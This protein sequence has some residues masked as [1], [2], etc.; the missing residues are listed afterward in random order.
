MQEAFSAERARELEAMQRSNRGILL[1]A[2]TFAAIGFL[3]LLIMTFFQWRT[4]RSLAEISAGL[5][6]ALGFGPGS[7]DPAL[8]PGDSRQRQG[9]PVEQ[10]NLRLL[11]AIDS[12]KSASRAWSR[13]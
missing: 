13:R 7:A 3:A 8:G 12:L 4:S 9:G 1:V 2:G 6:T 10:T 11:A 5:P